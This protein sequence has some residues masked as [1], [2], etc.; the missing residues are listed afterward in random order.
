MRKGYLGIDLGTTGTKSILF[1]EKDNV[2]GRGYQS[3]GLITPCDKF[4]EQNAEDWFDAVVNTVKTAVK[5]FDGEIA[6]ISFS[7]QGGSFLLCDIDEKG[8]LI[9]LTNALTWLDNRAGV[10]ADEL[11]EKVLEITGEN[12]GAGSGLSRLLWLK[13]N[14]QEEFNKTKLVLSTSDYIYYKLTGKAVIDYTSAAMMGVFDNE[15]LC[16]NEKLLEL[17]DMKVSQFPKIAGAGELIGKCNEEFLCLT[18]LRGDV[19]VYCGVHDQFA[20]SLGS[21]YF[22]DGDIIVSTGTTWVVFGK[23]DKKVDGIFSGRK[24][25]AGGYGYF[26][27]AMSSGTVL[28]WEKNFFGTNYDELNSEIGKIDF[29]P[30]LLVYPF[31]SGNGA[32]RGKNDLKFSVHN[33]NYNHTKFDMLK[34]TMEG[35][36]F[37]I[38]QIVNEYI[39]GGFNV[40]NIIVTGGATRSSVWM[41]ILSNVLGKK[42]FL[43]EQTDG[44]CFGAYSV[45]RKGADGEFIT[46]EFSGKTVEADET[47]TN[48]YSEKFLKYNKVLIE[49]Q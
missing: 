37:E 31:I 49:R 34:A 3:Y 47:L 16:W 28:E 1:D 48:R 35:V 14:C 21:N 19:N 6:G 7:A 29:D 20:A 30:E 42:L 27:S 8:N 25:P 11:S 36:A 12:I 26:I 33:M 38:K 18:G 32:Y 40:K 23:N 24:H 45:A 4:Y 13:K 39:N 46:F 17:V 41:Q 2:L 22:G 10:E 15:N 9:P 44:C 5:D 43:S